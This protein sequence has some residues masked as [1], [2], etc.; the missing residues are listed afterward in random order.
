MQTKR[1]LLFIVSLVF[2]LAAAS[3]GGEEKEAKKLML[4][5]Q[6]MISSGDWMG[7][8]DHLE[9]IIAEYPETKAAETARQMQESIIERANGLAE[10]VLKQAVVTAIGCRASYPGSD[11]TL[12]QLRNF[13]F[14]AEKDVEVEV[15]DPQANDFLISTWHVAG[16]GAWYCGPDG[17]TWFEEDEEEE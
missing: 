1:Y 2:V 9:M 13:G 10:I 16:D 17:Q 15:V 12:A 6:P 7:L 11:I 5:T 14:R 8:Q 3:C 4:Q